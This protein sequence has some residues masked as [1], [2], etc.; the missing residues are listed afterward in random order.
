MNRWVILS[1]ALLGFSAAWLTA[2]F[3]TAPGYMDAEYYFVGGLQLAEGKGFSEEI[4]WNYLDDPKG[5]PHPSHGYWMPLTSLAAALGMAFSGSHSFVGGQWIFL[6]I[7]ACIPPLTAH[8]SF[9]LTRRQNLA[10]LSGLLAVFPG[11]YLVYLPTSDSFGLCMLLGGLF[12]ASVGS[13]HKLAPLAMGFLAGLL[14]L[15]R[16]DGILWLSVAFIFVALQRRQPSKRL[17]RLGWLYSAGVCLAGYLIVMAPWMLRNLLV[18]GSPLSA[19]GSRS[20]WITQ[21]NEMFI[22]PASLLTAERW[23]QSGLGAILSAR[24]WALGLNLQTALAVQAEIFLA[25]LILV[26]L[27]RLRYERRVQAGLLAWG[28]TLAVMTI[29]FPYQG[30]RGGFFH[31]GAAI[32]PLFWA[33]AP[34][35]LDAFI[36]WGGRKRGWNVSQAGRVFSVALTLIA[37]VL[38]VTLTFRRLA[39]GEFSERAWNANQQRY[40]QVELEL[41]RR[42]V[43]PQAVIMV[44]NAPGYYAAGRR[45]AVSIPYGNLQTL[46]EVAKRYQAQ[47]LLVEV[48][49]V[50]GE[51]LLEHPG[52]R[53]GLE[54]WGTT[55]EARIYAI[56]Q[57]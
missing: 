12:L 38:T 26:G 15:S 25:P 47:I 5:I 39:G 50:Q 49:Q 45:P 27:W 44:N 9:L 4:L 8:L 52:D 20:L 10:L 48:E 37:I 2:R 13:A 55:A 6:A 36:E 31:S 35:G 16:A 40:T 43:D 11:F 24:G 19:G 7:A 30:G 33:V 23:L 29:V 41:A 56:Q 32:Q 21:Y 51:Q 17:A 54:Y 18:F 46:L 3:Q 22:Y 1:L 28:L 57:P 34:L 53:P 14:H 42:G